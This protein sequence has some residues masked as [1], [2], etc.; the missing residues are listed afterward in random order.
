MRGM[1]RLVDLRMLKPPI[2]GGAEK[3]PFRNVRSYMSVIARAIVASQTKKQ[4]IGW[5]RH[6]LRGHSGAGVKCLPLNPCC[7]RDTRCGLAT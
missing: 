1:N 3:K 7:L 2:G 4:R 6:F 5:L